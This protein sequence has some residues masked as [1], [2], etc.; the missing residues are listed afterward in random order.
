M[1]HRFVRVLWPSLGLLLGLLFSPALHAQDSDTLILRETL[2]VGP[3]QTLDL[4]RYTHVLLL[5]EASI[6]V[7]GSLIIQPTNGRTVRIS[8]FFREQ[9]GKGIVI[10]GNNPKAFI[11]LRNVWF[12]RL[13][14]AL[15]FEPF[16]NRSSVQI[17][18]FKVSR[19][20]RLQPAVMVHHPLLNLATEKLDFRVSKGRFFNNYSGLFFEKVG[21]NGTEWDLE[22]LAF[23]HNY[24]NNDGDPLGLLHMGLS[25]QLKAGR[26]KVSALY[27]DRNF[28]STGAAYALSTSGLSN[29]SL[30]ITEVS[31]EGGLQIMDRKVNPRL[32]QLKIQNATNPANLAPSC[33]PKVLS[34]DRRRIVL[35]GYHPSCGA[36]QVF[37]TGGLSL[38]HLQSDFGDTL[39]LDISGRGIP[40]YLVFENDNLRIL[41]KPLRKTLGDG[42]PV[43]TEDTLVGRIEYETMVNQLAGMNNLDLEN[44]SVVPKKVLAQLVKPGSSDT[45]V[46]KVEFQLLRQ[47]VDAVEG[48]ASLVL[49][50]VFP[51]EELS[52]STGL[53]F[54]CGD[55]KYQYGVP[56]FLDRSWS[57]AYE[58]RIKPLRSFRIEGHF[59][60]VGMFDRT[61]AF[62]FGRIKE[63]VLVDNNFKRYTVDDQSQVAFR[64]HIFG[65]SY[66]QIYTAPMAFRNKTKWSLD[67]G[68]GAGI[69]RFDPYRVVSYNRDRALNR[70]SVALIPLRSVGTEGQNYQPGLVL[71][72][73]LRLD[74]NLYEYG[75]YA[76][77]LNG[78]GRLSY[79]NNGLRFFGEVKWNL[80]LTDYLDDFGPGQLYANNYD[81]WAK[82]NANLV[83]PQN[84]T[85]VNASTGEGTPYR[86]NQIFRRMPSKQRRTMGFLPDSY[87]QIHF[88]LS[89]DLKEIRR[90]Y[91]DADVPG[92]IRRMRR[93]RGLS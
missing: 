47:K 37:G 22:N 19:C 11:R 53:A 83:L 92:L 78:M 73:P 24:E 39:Q 87:V 10:T 36:V 85:V 3:N 63:T 5:P 1:H 35:Q 77:L 72:S 57:I 32:P 52:F 90:V 26:V 93:P 46:G 66:N 28:T 34:Q 21:G 65:L 41:L 6:W 23:Y 79:R 13:D 59:T 38:D 49:R 2:T 17:E 44:D 16:W 29:Q 61:A 9:S 40:S 7:E 74:A 27:F 68:W 86:L 75:P 33:N 71:S 8:S 30:T 60:R 80:A 70:D 62:A 58:K 54:Y 31:A 81:A 48:N 20:G 25:E 12:D 43:S 15:H 51:Q 88:G 18:D 69:I 89:Y 64:T 42:D 91:R 4:S 56:T 14:Q 67:Y 76:I 50:P 55:L 45:I 82:A 84:P